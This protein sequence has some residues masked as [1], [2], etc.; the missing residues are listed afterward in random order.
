VYAA[1]GASPE[2]S[3]AAARWG[4][5]AGPDET[6]VVVDAPWHPV[7]TSTKASRRATAPVRAGVR[8]RASAGFRAAGVVIVNERARHRPTGRPFRGGVM[9]VNRS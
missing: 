8:A 5:P 2:T 3:M 6:G 7:S 4:M 1:R 9:A